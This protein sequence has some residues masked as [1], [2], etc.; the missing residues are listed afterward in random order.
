MYNIE[1]KT[2][3]K[4][5]EIRLNNL[6]QDR[7]GRLCKVERIESDMISIH[8]IKS[9]TTSLPC[10]PIELTEQYL[11]DFGFEEIKSCNGDCGEWH[12]GKNEITHDYL[13][14]LTWLR[15]TSMEDDLFYL[16]G[17]HKLKYVH[18]L[19]NLYF[20]LTGEELTLKEKI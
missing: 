3:I 9:S 6:F 13:F 15:W 19:Q 4:P 14:S 11:L 1:E 10:E 17:R 8:A 12:I 18:Q 20:A 5:T 16:N 2:M 7:K